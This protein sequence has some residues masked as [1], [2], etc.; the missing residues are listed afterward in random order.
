MTGFGLMDIAPE[1]VPMSLGLM[2]R[3]ALRLAEGDAAGGLGD[4]L[5]C[6]ARLVATGS[7]NPATM[8]WRSLAAR[9]HA[10]LSDRPAALALAAQELDLARRFGAP[11]PLGVALRAHAV[12]TG[13]E[14]GLAQL[15]EAVSVLERSQYR[16]EHAH[17][18][19]DLGAALR[20]AGRRREAREL[21]R[22][23][24]ELAAGCDARP[25]VARAEAELGTSAPNLVRRPHSGLDALTPG[26]RRVAALAAEGKTNAQIAQSLFLSLKT[27]EMHLGRTYRK[28]GIARRG[29]LAGRL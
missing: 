16:L 10:Q 27:V 5:A 29:G 13:G 1:Q 7:T 17:A 20:R 22:Q 12:L 19:V 14:E 28:L 24:L 15:R 6:G 9:A 8:P 18:L 26:E 11:G 2:A 25:L 21:L 23:G 4:L 3:G